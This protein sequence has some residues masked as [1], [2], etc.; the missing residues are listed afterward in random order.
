MNEQANTKSIQVIKS[1]RYR[2]LF[3]QWYAIYCMHHIRFK[4]STPIIMNIIEEKTM[5]SVF[6]FTSVSRFMFSLSLCLS[7]SFLFSPVFLSVCILIHRPFDL[8]LSIFAFLVEYCIL[9]R[10][11]RYHVLFSMRTMLL[12]APIR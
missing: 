3:A 4:C 8:S 2:S 12:G 1:T 7:V 10:R 11:R 9:C 5:F 6:V